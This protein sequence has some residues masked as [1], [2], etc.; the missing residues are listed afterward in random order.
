MPVFFFDCRTWCCGGNWGLDFVDIAKCIDKFFS[1]KEWDPVL[2][3][4]DLN[5]LLDHGNACSNFFLLT[6]LEIGVMGE[7]RVWTL[8]FFCLSKI[9]DGS[10]S[11]CMMHDGYW[12]VSRGAFGVYKHQNF[13]CWISMDGCLLLG[14]LGYFAC[15]QF[16]RAPKVYSSVCVMHEGYWHVSR[17]ALGVCEYQNFFQ[18]IS[19]GGCL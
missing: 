18:K 11:V 14:D 10:E 16:S 7:V 15:Q 17:G 8:S 1:E 13:I 5:I 19:V 4:G 6:G 9:F 2:V 12:H 3:L